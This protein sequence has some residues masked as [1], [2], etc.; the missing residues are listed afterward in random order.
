MARKIRRSIVQYVCTCA[1]GETIALYVQPTL[2]EIK[3]NNIIS[4][5]P[6]TG[7]YEMNIETFVSVARRVDV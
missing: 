7:I 2:K 4:V 5:Q 1:G 6:E 3:E